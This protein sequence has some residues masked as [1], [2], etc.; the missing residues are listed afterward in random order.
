MQDDLLLVVAEVHIL[1]DDVALQLGVSD[2]AIGVL[3]F[4]GPDAG[5]LVDLGQGVVG[6]ELGM[7]QGDVALVDL[8][9]FLPQAPLLSA[10]RLRRH[11]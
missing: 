4:P 7:H 1:K 11:I 9:L 5:G 10:Q 3:L 6:L 2:S 8:G